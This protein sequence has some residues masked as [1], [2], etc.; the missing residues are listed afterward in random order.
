MN[1]VLISIVIVFGFLDYPKAP[2]HNPHSNNVEA[3]V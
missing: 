2:A 1:Y 3:F